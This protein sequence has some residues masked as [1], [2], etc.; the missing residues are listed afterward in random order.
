[1]SVQDQVSPNLYEA[2][3]LLRQD[4]VANDFSGCVEF[5]RTSFERAEAE[6]LVFKRWDERRLATEFKGQRRGVFLLA[7]FNAPGARIAGIERDCAL[8]DQVLRCLITRADHVGEAELAEAAADKETDLGVKR[9]IVEPADEQPAAAEAA[10]SAESEAVVETPEQPPAVV[11]ATPAVEV[12]TPAVEDATPVVE[13][14][15][16]VVED[17]TPAPAASEEEPPE[18]GAQA[19]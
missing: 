19:E 6:V 3:F 15:T 16:P 11:D 17:A 9:P 10:A 14:T 8:S 2:M 7:Y 4:A 1:V 18:A 5:V 13:D 12:A